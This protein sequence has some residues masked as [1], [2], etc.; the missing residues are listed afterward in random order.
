MKLIGRFFHSMID[1]ISQKVKR[2]YR[3]V[4]DIDHVRSSQIDY[5]ASK[6]MSLRGQNALI[7]AEE[8]VKIDGDQ[9]HLG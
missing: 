5:R 3:V 6:N 4:E 8:L 9:I 2:S 1:S 7:N